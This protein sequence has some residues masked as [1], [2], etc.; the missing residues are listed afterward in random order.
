VNAILFANGV[1]TLKGYLPA[2]ME[3]NP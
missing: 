3:L 1:H 2:A